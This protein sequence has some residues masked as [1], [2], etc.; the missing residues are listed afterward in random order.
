MHRRIPASGRRDRPGVS[1]AKI[2]G[3]P[4]PEDKR[5][6]PLVRACRLVDRGWAVAVVLVVTLDCMRGHLALELVAERAARQNEPPDGVHTLVESQQQR[7]L[8][9]RRVSRWLGA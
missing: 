9:V 3:K 4:G 5:Q 6:I 7:R 8:D 1:T 2:D